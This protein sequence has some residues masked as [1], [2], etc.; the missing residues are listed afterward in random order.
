MRV[1]RAS[2]HK[3]D[4][5]VDSRSW[6]D[7]NANMKFVLQAETMISCLCIP[8]VVQKL[9]IFSLMNPLEYGRLQSYS[10]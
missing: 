7:K 5:H 8:E 1:N 10:R 3:T 4:N 2:K 6:I 9:Y